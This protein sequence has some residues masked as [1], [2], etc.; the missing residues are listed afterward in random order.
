MHGVIVSDGPLYARV[1]LCALG[2][3]HHQIR[4][5]RVY[6]AYYFPT[7]DAGVCLESACVCCGAEIV[8]MKWR[9]GVR[10]K[11]SKGGV[12]GVLGVEGGGGQV[13]GVDGARR[14]RR[15]GW[16]RRNPRRLCEEVGCLSRD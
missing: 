11:E 6:V 4:K 16:L 14:Q 2:I 1:C 7:S 12:K 13:G 15:S 10:Y 8:G 3:V 5:E 9:D